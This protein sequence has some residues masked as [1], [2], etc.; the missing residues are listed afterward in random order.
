MAK[1]KHLTDRRKV[2]KRINTYFKNHPRAKDDTTPKKIPSIPKLM[3]NFGK[4]IVKDSIGGRVRV[5]LGVFAYRINQ[6]NDCDEREGDKCTNNKCG[7]R[8]TK[9]CWWAK[10]EC[11][12]DPPRWKQWDGPKNGV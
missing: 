12:Q 6:C 8:L 2:S 9:K 4:A 7:C 5:P 10:E 1:R 3:Y 11:P